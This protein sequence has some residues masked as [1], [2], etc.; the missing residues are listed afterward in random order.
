MLRLV[1]E[2]YTSLAEVRITKDPLTLLKSIHLTRELGKLGFAAI[3]LN[4][5]KVTGARDLRFKE[6]LPKELDFS[7]P[8]SNKKEEEWLKYQ[9]IL[10]DFDQLDEKS[11]R[12]LLLE[13]R[14]AR[15][16]RK[17]KV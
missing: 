3:I 5:G 14:M 1:D 8:L 2:L 12:Q 11:Q 10:R 4:K 17:E 7:P 9:Q 15:R 6:D 13:L 16:M